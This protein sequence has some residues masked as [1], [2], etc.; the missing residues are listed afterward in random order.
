M[1]LVRDV[2]SSDSSGAYQELESNIRQLQGTQNNNFLG[3]VFGG[4]LIS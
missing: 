1:M 3:A 2:I 4:T